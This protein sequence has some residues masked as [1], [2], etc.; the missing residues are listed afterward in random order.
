MERRY[1]T[2]CIIK[3]ELGDDAIQEI[4]KKAS[5]S[6]E[7]GAGSINMLDEWGRRR[8]SYPIQKKHEGF[9]VLFDYTSTAE[10]SKSLE[11][12]FRLNESVVRYQTV[13]LEGKAAVR[14]A[15]KQAALAA[16]PDVEAEATPEAKTEAKAEATPEAKTEVKTEVKTEATPEA[17][18]EA[19]PEAKTEVKTEAAPEPAADDKGSE[20]GKDD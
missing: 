12:A 3:S 2:I 14:A 11:R 20:G 17:K 13:R 4:V 18:T 15:A 5:A 16:K 6:I 8:L 7:D 10:V 19:T 1:E 9:Y